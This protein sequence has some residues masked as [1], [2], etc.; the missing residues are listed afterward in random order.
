MKRKVYTGLNGGGYCLG[1]FL[2]GLGIRHLGGREG[3][4]GTE[5]QIEPAGKLGRAVQKQRAFRAAEGRRTRL[6]R[7]GTDEGSE[8]NRCA[9]S[10][11]LGQGAAGQRLGKDLRQGAGDG[12]RAHRAGQNERRHD[13]GLVGACVNLERAEHGGVEHE[14]GIGV[15]Q[16]DHHA[17]LV[18][19]LLA[20]HDLRHLHRIFRPFR[21]RDRTHERLVGILDVG[22]HHVEMALVH[23]QVDRFANGAAGVVHPWRHVGQLHEIAEILDRAVAPAVVE[24]RDEGRAVDR[25]EHKVVTADFHAS[26][27]IAR[28]LG[29]LGGRRLDEF[30]KHA[31]RKTDPLAINLRAGR[32]PDVQNLRILAELQADLRQDPVGVGFDLL[33]AFIAQD[34]IERDVP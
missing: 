31:L 9:R 1:R 30:L 11:E 3:A 25:R 12:H 8:D 7:N 20:E 17:V 27:R 23:R 29:E 5:R 34:I 6:H 16:L 32:L 33:S 10:E 22:I 15:D 26:G 2:G 19:E 21:C 14:R 18:D 24:I 4:S 28:V 13:A